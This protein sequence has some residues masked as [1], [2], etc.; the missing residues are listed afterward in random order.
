MEEDKAIISEKIFSA[1]NISNIELFGV[2]KHHLEAVKPVYPIIEFII[3][4]LIAVTN[5]SIQSLVWDAEIVYRSALET[6]VKFLYITTA[7]DEEQPTRLNEFWEDLEEIN[8]IK[9]SE[10]AKKN[11]KLFNGQEI[12]RLAFS[13]LLLSEEHENE[14][15]TKWPRVKRKQLEQKWSFSQIVVALSLNYRGYPMESFIGLTHS[16]RMASHVSHGDETGILIIRERNS[17]ILREKDIADFSH[18][19]RLMSDSFLFT[20]WTGIETLMFLKQDPKFFLELKKS[21]EDLNP[22]LD[23]YHLQVFDDPLYN[24][25]R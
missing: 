9:L 2:M 7:T 12:S 6:F 13:P 4:R 14:L 10:Q 22:I 1:I 11:L 16:Y 18:F 8:K 20:V 17:R 23:K 24:R 3:E 21:L 25:F 19:L 15:R 5:L